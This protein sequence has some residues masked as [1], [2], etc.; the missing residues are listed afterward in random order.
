VQA[1]AEIRFRV[2]PDLKAKFQHECDQLGLPG[3]HVLRE[4]LLDFVQDS[5][6]VPQSDPCQL[7]LF[8]DFTTDLPKEPT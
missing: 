3:S 8:S 2:H 6:W 7:D 1:R 5:S 4:F